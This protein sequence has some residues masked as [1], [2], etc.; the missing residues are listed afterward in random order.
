[1][2]TWVF[3]RGYVTSLTR[4]VSAMM[5]QP[6]E[7]GT[8]SCGS[9]SKHQQHARP[10]THFKRMCMVTVTSTI[11]IGTMGSYLSAT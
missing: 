6:Y 4:A 2:R 7:Y 11:T 5:D 8:C 1:M 10:T 9:P 3:V